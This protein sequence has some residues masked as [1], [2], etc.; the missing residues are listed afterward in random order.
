MGMTAG[1]GVALAV[2]A[3][4]ADTWAVDTGHSEVSFRVRHFVSQ[5][6]G[7][8]NTFEGTIQVDHDNPAASDVSF[9]IKADS[10]DTG[11][12]QRDGHLRS[13]DFFDVE[14]YPEITFQS[15]KVEAKGD[16]LYDVTGVF[17]LHGVTKELTLPVRY[18]GSLTDNRGN[19]KAGFETEVTI[20][21]QEY[22]ITFNRALDQGGVMLG[23]DVR[24]RISLE[25]G[26][27][28]EPRAN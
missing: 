1:L 16:D 9:N 27:P 22:G 23:D 8:F 18:L 14:K 10:I 3:Q 25:V 24:V 6:S 4:A 20:D 11:N 17:T 28:P 13:P 15:S 2:A 21:R 19:T 5:V 7:R 26:P 12:E